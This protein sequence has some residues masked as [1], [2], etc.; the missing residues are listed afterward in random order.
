MNE[1]GGSRRDFVFDA[2]RNTYYHKAGIY[3]DPVTNS[4]LDINR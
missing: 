2:G 4:Y 1:L 3:Y